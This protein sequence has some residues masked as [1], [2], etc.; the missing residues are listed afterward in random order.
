MFFF[1]KARRSLNPCLYFLDDMPSSHGGVVLL[2]TYSVDVRD[3]DLVPRS[4]V[5]FHARRHAGL[6]AARQRGSGLGY[7]FIEAALLEL[8]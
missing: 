8:L 4:H 2:L 6:L 7:A 3:I 5:F 1:I